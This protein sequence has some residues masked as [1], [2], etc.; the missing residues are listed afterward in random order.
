MNVD[1]VDQMTMKH[2]T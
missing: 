2:V 1:S